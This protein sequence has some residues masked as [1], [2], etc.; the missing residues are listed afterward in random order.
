[1]AYTCDR[2]LVG[3]H[4][5]CARTD[6]AC[7]I[8]GGSPSPYKRK[9]S[10]QRKSRAKDPSEL[11][12][13]GT[14]PMTRAEKD[15]TLDLLV[16]LL[17]GIRDDGYRVLTPDAT[18]KVCTVCDASKPLDQFYW[19]SDRNMYRSKCKDCMKDLRQLSVSA[20]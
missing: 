7:S 11:N 15:E 14:R 18:D 12:V 8:C 9:K 17:T 3:D 19:R 5:R 13:G 1:M 2:C 20:P 4:R 10:V 6:C 16:K